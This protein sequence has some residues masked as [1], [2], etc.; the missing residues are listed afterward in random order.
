[1]AYLHIKTFPRHRPSF[2][3]KPTT[4]LDIKSSGHLSARQFYIVGYYLKVPTENE[5]PIAED[6][7]TT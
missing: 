1:M 2:P 6:V 4:Y 7:P 3:P 5:L